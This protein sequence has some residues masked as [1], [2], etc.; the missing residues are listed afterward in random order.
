MSMQADAHTA[1]WEGRRQPPAALL[2]WLR[3]SGAAALTPCDIPTA[4]L[5]RHRHVH[6]LQTQ[7]AG[8]SQPCA[9]AGLVGLR[10]PSRNGSSPEAATRYKPFS[11]RPSLS[12]AVKVGP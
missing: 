1:T 2:G 4:L 7:E 12:T 5:L 6:S 9:D 3:T 8:R 10:T 11:L